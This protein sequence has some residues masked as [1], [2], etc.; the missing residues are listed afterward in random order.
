MRPLRGFSAA[1][2]DQLWRASLSSTYPHHP[3][4]MRSQRSAS[5]M[6]W[7]GMKTVT[8]RGSVTE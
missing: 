2:L 1:L 7:V 4:D 5:F 6:K 8:G 3:T